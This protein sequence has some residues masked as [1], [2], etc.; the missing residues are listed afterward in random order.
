MIMHDHA[1]IAM[2]IHDHAV[3]A[4]RVTACAVRAAP[5]QNRGA[6]A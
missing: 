4:R 3:H 6:V 5:E 2:I 1:V